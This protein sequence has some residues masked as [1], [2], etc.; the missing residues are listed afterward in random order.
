MAADHDYGP[1]QKGAHQ[2]THFFH[3]SHV[4][5]DRTYTDNIVL[6]VP[7]LA[8][9][10]IQVRKIQKRTRYVDIGLN[11]QQAERAMKHSQGKGPLNPGN[12]VMIE[13]HGVDSSTS[14]IIVLGIGPKNACQQNLCFAAEFVYGMDIH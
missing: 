11:H 12:L 7:D 1:R 6:I 2:F 9:K 10:S 8:H 14:I 13:F 3:L 5:Y 4:G